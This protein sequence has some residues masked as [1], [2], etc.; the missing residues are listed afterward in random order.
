MGFRVG[1][2]GQDLGSGSG[3]RVRIQG[4]DFVSMIGAWIQGKDLGSKIQ[5]QDS[6][7]G[8]RVGI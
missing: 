6:V 3:I 7:L 8:F 5:G 1:I 2:Q 4:Q